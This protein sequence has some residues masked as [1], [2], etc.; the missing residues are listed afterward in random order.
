MSGSGVE[1]QVVGEVVSS[2]EVVCGV[3][4]LLRLGGALGVDHV[5]ERSGVQ[6]G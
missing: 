5:G 1:A 3:M 6:E 2:F 4:N